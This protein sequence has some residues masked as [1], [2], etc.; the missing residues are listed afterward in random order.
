MFQRLKR[1]K[2]LTMHAKKL[3]ALTIV[4]LLAGCNSS[5]SIASGPIETRAAK[6]ANQPAPASAPG[7]VVGVS[8]SPEQPT[9][10]SLR[11]SYHQ[12]ASS[13]D[14][15]TWDMEDCIEKEFKYQDDRLNSTYRMLLSKLAPEAR[16][17]LKT[18]ERQWLANK[19]AACK[20]DAETE[21]QAQRIE[22]NLCSLERTADR[23]TRLDHMLRDL[24]VH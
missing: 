4:V 12:C 21:G 6:S 14:G 23:A 3:I 15:S 22:A 24:P 2:G 20:W 10:D 16:K 19:D 18:E 13:N 5:S 7:V 1:T 17:R 8:S 11:D 9:N